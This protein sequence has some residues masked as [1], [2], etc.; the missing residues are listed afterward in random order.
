MKVTQHINNFTAVSALATLIL[1]AGPL[2]SVAQK[3]KNRV[4]P[5]EA[6]AKEETIWM[7]QNLYLSDVQY[8]MAKS[9]NLMYSCKNDSIENLRDKQVLSQN[10]SLLQKDKDAAFRSFLSEDQY[11][12]Y[13][14]HKDKKVMKNKSPFEGSY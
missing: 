14:T 5:C 10:K 12:Q 6:K 9:I 11:K 2:P 4:P 7:H 13:L 8:D 3:L 1:S